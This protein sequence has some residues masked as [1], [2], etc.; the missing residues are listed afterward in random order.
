[1]AKPLPLEQRIEIASRLALKAK[2]HFL[3]WRLTTGTDG[4]LQH[5][6]VFQEYW[7]AIRFLQNGQLIAAVVD[8]HALCERRADTINLATLIA[9]M[10]AGGRL[11]DSEKKLSKAQGSIRKIVLLRSAAIAHRTSKKAYNDVFTAANI[12]PNEIQDLIDLTIEITGDLLE[13]SGKE[14]PDLNPF[15][16]ETYRR[17]FNDLRRAVDEDD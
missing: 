6:P 7:E 4:H 10:E 9:E 17:M 8:L 1:M 16:L 12:T 15:P 11:L 2:Q 5:R 13:V 3:L 14:R